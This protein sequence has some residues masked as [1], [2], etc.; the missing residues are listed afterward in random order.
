V[1]T[2]RNADAV[3]RQALCDHRSRVGRFGLAAACL[4]AVA[5][6]SVADVV[7]VAL[8]RVRRHA[9]GMVWAMG[10]LV[11]AIVCGRYRGGGV[12]GASVAALL[13]FSA[14]PAWA[15]YTAGV[16][17]PTLQMGTTCSSEAPGM[18][19]S[20]VA[21]AVTKSRAM[22]TCSRSASAGR[23][24]RSAT[25]QTSRREQLSRF[26]GADDGSPAAAGDLGDA[27]RL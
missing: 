3:S 17:S 1:N 13:G 7:V 4:W 14:A 18:T 20:S 22:A 11:A 5:K 21:V 15:S 2:A 8:A 19:R 23:S 26:G 6:A 27:D 12:L 24:C 25:C 9:I 10:F 16:Q